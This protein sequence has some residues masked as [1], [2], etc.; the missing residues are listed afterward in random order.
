LYLEEKAQAIGQWPKKLRVTLRRFCACSFASARVARRAARVAT[1]GENLVNRNEVPVQ[2]HR[3]P[4]QDEPGLVA[5]PAAAGTAAPAFLQVE[6]A[7]EGVQL[8][9]GLQQTRL[10][11]A[12]E[13]PAETDDRFAG[14]VAVEA[15]AAASSASPHSTA[16]PTTSTSTSHA[17]CCGRSSRSTARRSPGPT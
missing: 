8:L 1:K 4:R 5:E 3:R 9:Q 15:A 10:L 2:P 6:S 16:G 14:L 11:C 7:G 13:G 12:E 17:A